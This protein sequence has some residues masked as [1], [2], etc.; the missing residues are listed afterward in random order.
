MSTALA[1]GVL[2]LAALHE[3]A[4][5]PKPVPITLQARKAPKGFLSGLRRRALDAI[6]VPLDDFF[7]GTDLQWFGN[8]SGTSNSHVKP[9]I[10]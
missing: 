6:E 5:V 9:Y 8:I 7:Q 3:V 10:D 2:A 4:A 1:L